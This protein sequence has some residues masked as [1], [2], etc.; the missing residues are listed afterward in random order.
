[1]LIRLIYLSR[2]TGPQ[3]GELTDAILQKSQRWNALHDITGMLCEGQ[4]VFLQVIEGERAQVTRLYARIA[5]DARH[6]VATAQGLT[7]AITTR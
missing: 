3:A 5:A 2:A 4:G 6:C 7:P 1:M